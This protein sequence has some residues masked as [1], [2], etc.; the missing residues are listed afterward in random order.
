[1][2]KGDMA[3]MNEMW[4]HGDDVT[5]MSPFGG[6]QTGWNNV[7]AELTREAANNMAG[8]VIPRDLVIRVDGNMA[9]AICVEEGQNFTMGGKP[10]NISHRATSVYRKENGE[11]KLI[12]HHTDP[13]PQLQAG[14]RR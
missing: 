1:M 10:A 5:L 7:Q 14:A 9:C 12:H 3:L 8:R 11:W 4:S 6:R 2:F 13:A